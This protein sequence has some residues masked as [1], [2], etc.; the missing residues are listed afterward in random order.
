MRIRLQ[1]MPVMSA[2]AVAALVVLVLL[3]TWQWRRYEQKVLVGAEAPAIVA[4]E[5]FEIAPGGVQFVFGARDSRPGWRVFQPVRYGGRTVFVDAG[6][7]EGAGAPDWRTTPTPK[8]LVNARAV[9]G[10]AV[11]PQA[12][13]A[14]AARGDPDARLWYSVDLASMAAAAGLAD[15]EP[16]YVATP[17]LDATG[18]AVPNSFAL[19]AAAE[20]LPPERHLGYALTWWG[21][22]I[23][24]VGVYLAFHARQG[25]FSIR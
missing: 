13:G 23:A 9:S 5:P 6:Y 22:A 20:P 16:Y 24:L 12:A 3:G 14:F 4:L 7:V 11:R 18:A 8:A 21:L 1:P 19:G 15:V 25:R 17:H 10:V 2:F